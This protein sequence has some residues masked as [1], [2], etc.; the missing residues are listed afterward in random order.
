MVLGAEDVLAIN[1]LNTEDH[2]VYMYG[3]DNGNFRP[4]AS[5][6]RAEVA[7]IF[8]NLLIN[9]DV[10]ITTTFSDVP[11]DQWYAKAVNTLASMGILS[12]VG[13]NKFEPTRMITRAEFAVIAAKFVDEI[14]ADSSFS[15]V[16]ETHWAYNSISTAATYGW[17]S[18]VGDNMYA[19]SRA[20]KRVEAVTIVNNMLGR[21][22]DRDKID[23]GLC[24]QFPDVSKSHWGWYQIAE[25]TTVH[26]HSFDEYR[27]VETWID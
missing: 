10:A 6:T 17:I 15:D 4:D 14:Q 12:G 2:I 24:R 23:M 13:E 7:Q 11:A 5:V 8:Y 16:P 27:T 20:I 21:L 1:Y 25:A 26:D 3:D 22:G 18:G 9:K 19:P